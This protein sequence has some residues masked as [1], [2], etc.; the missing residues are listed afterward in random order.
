MD[1][2]AKST[3]LYE[4]DCHGTFVKRVD[5]TEAMAIASAEPSLRQIKGVNVNSNISTTK[6]LSGTI[7]SNTT[8]TSDTLFLNGDLSIT[9][10]TKVTFL[11][12]LVL[13]A[14]G[15]KIKAMPQSTL[16]IKNSVFA[17]KNNA[18]WKGI[19]ANSNYHNGLGLLID[20]S[21][22][23]NADNGIST[24]KMSEMQ[25]SQSIIATTN[26]QRAIFMDR[27]QKQFIVNDNLIIGY[28]E[29][30]STSR[31]QSNLASKI[32]NNQFLDVKRIWNLVNDNFTNAEFACNL[33]KGF[34]DGVISKSSSLNDQGSATLSAGNVFSQS[35]V[36][37][38]YLKLS[39]ANT[40][41]YFGPSQ[42]AQFSISNISNI[43]LIQAGLDR[44]CAQTFAS[45][46]QPLLNPV[47]IKENSFTNSQILIYPNPSSGTFNLSTANLSGNYVLNIQDVLGRLISSQKLT[48]SSDKVITF[49]ILAKGLYFVTLENK[50]NRLTQK[51]VVE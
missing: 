48:L 28:A 45:D 19:S 31:S 27:G 18:T 25:I 39:S 23:L 42:S 12:C 33:M 24:D 22:I 49:E 17:G 2:Q 41:Y 16:E 21:V 29:G 3:V 11:N 4:F 26:G 40:K 46:C 9:A 44:M 13:V 51:I 10:N 30:I 36:Q 37:Q 32:T 50:E 38:D 7:T 35:G 6:T 14:P 43:P 5:Y 20:K 8:F 47:G 15:K 1:I 34:T